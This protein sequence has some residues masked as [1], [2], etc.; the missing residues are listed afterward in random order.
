L[1]RKLLEVEISR[2]PNEPFD[3]KSPYLSTRRILY[4]KASWVEFFIPKSCLPNFLKGQADRD[5]IKSFSIIKSGPLGKR[6]R[7]NEANADGFPHVEQSEE[8]GDRQSTAARKK[9]RM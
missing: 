7:G 3:I 1:S 9:V 4:Y 8:A 6:K 2:P 5:G